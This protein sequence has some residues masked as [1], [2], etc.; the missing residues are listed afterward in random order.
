[1]SS[2]LDLEK[3]TI[4]VHAGDIAEINA[5]YP[6]LGYNAVIRELVHAHIRRKKHEQSKLT[7]A[8]ATLSE[9]DLEL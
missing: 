4:R 1:M 2:A 8:T 9:D 7:H 6:E 5:L 3:V